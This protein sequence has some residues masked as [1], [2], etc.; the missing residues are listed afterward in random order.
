[1]SEFR[2][3]S[4]RA[5]GI[6]TD[7]DWERPRA[8]PPD[9]RHPYAGELEFLHAQAKREVGRSDR[10]RDWWKRKVSRA[11]TRLCVSRRIYIEGM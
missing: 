3:D 4:P 5:W 9:K 7:A 11:F 10:E 1:M 2:C 8:K 6:T